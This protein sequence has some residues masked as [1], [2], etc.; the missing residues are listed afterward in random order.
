MQFDTNGGSPIVASKSISF[1][2]ENIPSSLEGAGEN[3]RPFIPSPYKLSTNISSS[4]VCE[5]GSRD[6][7]DSGYSGSI[8]HVSLMK[9]REQS[10]AELPRVFIVKFIVF[11]H[12]RMNSSRGRRGIP[13]C[14]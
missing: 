13:A 14:I 2:K 5:E 11:S 1:D 9:F 7:Q 8:E 3:A 10:L 6:S 4:L 12:F